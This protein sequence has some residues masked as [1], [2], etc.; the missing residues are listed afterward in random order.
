MRVALVHDYMIEFGG[1]E[2]VLEALHE[3]FPEAPIFTAFLDLKGLGPHGKRVK[4][5]DIR[6]SWLQSFPFGRKLISPFRVFAPMI[7]EGFDLK[8]YDLVISSCN[9]YFSKAVITRPDALHLSYIH[10]PP[11][12]L[13]GYTT[14]FN[15]KKHWWTRVLGELANHFLRIYDFETSQRPDILIANSKNIQKRI[16]KF[17][18]RDSVVIY[19][20][21]TLPSFP[22]RI[23]VRG[24]LRRE[25]NGSPIKSGMT[26]DK[27]YFLSISRLVK[28]KGVEVIVE[29]CVKLGVPLKVVG[30]G[31]ELEN[32][33]HIAHN[34]SHITFLG[35]V[36]DEDLG[37][38]Y[39]NAK[40][41]IVSSEDE[42]F[43]ITAVEA[44]AAGTPVIA[45]KAGGYL[46][47]VIDPSTGSASSPQASSG[48]GATGIFF[49]MA[50]VESLMEALEKFDQSKFKEEDLKK[51]AQK[52]SKE[53]FKK[54]ILELVE[55]NLKK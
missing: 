8:K 42:D 44:Q 41:L 35:E 39:A 34:L 2:R 23:S 7:F 15:Y 17:Y 21:V 43:G 3:I 9:T 26:Q 1:A 54:E 32:L 29:A 30:T 20:P 51:N 22:P 46:E 47:T 52:F 28:G 16:E 6:T 24:K 53:R 12:Y 14:S 40:A 25:S 18:R 10:T 37:D 50:T 36:G 19:P 4:T 31:P 45:V 27:K 55:K 49:D 11:R 33:K 5:W 38:I 13:Y 48:Q